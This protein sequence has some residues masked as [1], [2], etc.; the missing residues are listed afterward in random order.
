MFKLVLKLAVMLLLGNA[1]YRVG[2]EYLTYIKFRDDVRDAAMFRAHNDAELSREIMELAS[3]YDLP[4]AE[5]AIALNRQDHRVR[6]EGS[7]DKPIEVAPTFFY[8]WHFAWSID[9][10]VSI[11]V[12]PFTPRPKP[13]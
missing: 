2:S 6:V 9:A 5:S 1:V 12:P 7:Y 13:R 11:V 3:D 10:T 8:P 4:L